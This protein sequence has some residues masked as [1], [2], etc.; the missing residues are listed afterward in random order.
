MKPNLWMYS[1]DVEMRSTAASL[2]IFGARV[3]KSAKIVR[4]IDLLN[5]LYI[6]RNNE[7]IAPNDQRIT[8]FAFEYLTDCIKIV[9]FFENYMKAE[10]IAKGFCIH[11][12]KKDYSNFENLAKEQ[13]KKPVF[14]RE[15]HDIKP[16][17]VDHVNRTIYHPAIKES[18]I[19]FGELT[20]KP[21]YASHYRF[22]KTTLH[23]IKEMNFKR[24]KLHFH[25]SIDFELSHTLI[26]EIRNMSSFVDLVVNLFIRHPNN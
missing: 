12:I 19:G 20:N 14:I 4:E 1:T 11:Q 16:F 26:E 25:D 24:N 3:F 6:G 21:D 2:M 9:I 10:L 8:D 15:I 17:Q 18:T 23:H 7:T 5:Q 13:Q 22:D